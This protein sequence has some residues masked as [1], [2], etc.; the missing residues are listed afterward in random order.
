MTELYNSPLERPPYDE[1]IEA[2][3]HTKQPVINRV[4]ERDRS[5]MKQKLEQRAHT[6]LAL[7][8]SDL[9]DA[10]AESACPPIIKHLLTGAVGCLGA[11]VVGASVGS[12]VDATGRGPI[13]AAGGAIAGGACAV[14]TDVYSSR[15]MMKRRMRYNSLQALESIQGELADCSTEF[16]LHYHSSQQELLEQVETLYL[17][18]EPKSEEW[19][20][21]AAICT[22]GVVSFVLTFPAGLP[23][24]LASAIFPI[25][26]N[27]LVAKVQ[28]D[29]FEVPEAC[30]RLIPAYEVHI[31]LET[32][33]PQE[34]L[35]IERLDAGLQYVGQ[36]RP[37]KGLRSVGQA[38]GVAQMRF[39]QERMAVLEQ[40]GVQ[41]VVEREQ[42]YQ[43]DLKALPSQCPTPEINIAGLT[44]AEARQAAEEWRKAWLEEEERKLLEQL[45]SDLARIKAE[46]GQAIAYWRGVEAQGVQ[47]YRDTEPGD[48]TP[49]VA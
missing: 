36:A 1:T 43:E 8:R 25:I 33:M 28:S 21:I 16:E 20:A 47:Q 14:L 15:Y 10:I 31:P 24:A 3:K 45:E 4:E 35:D 37:P 41:A 26:V 46:Y 6:N 11:L 44:E 23:L 38:Q 12:V 48:D 27:L 5:G 19:M 32:I 18:K 39:A 22:E 40:H 7:Q 17:A 49:K 9:L 42:Q 29:R 30:E 2:W 34:A 13:A